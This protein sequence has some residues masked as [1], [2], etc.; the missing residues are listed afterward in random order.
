MTAAALI[1]DLR[2]RGV[3]LTAEGDCPRYR[4]PAGALGPE[5][6]AA[7][8]E[9]KPALLAALRGATSPGISAPAPEH[10]SALRQA[11]GT[12]WADLSAGERQV[13][14]KVRDAYAG[15]FDALLLRYFA[16][17][18]ISAEAEVRVVLDLPDRVL[19]QR[20]GQP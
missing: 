5:D 8:R 19:G 17:G 14:G 3:V 9:A 1:H 13:I 4:A 15:D 6:L 7:L 10:L 11:R 18:L 2:C 20:G 16:E 12:T